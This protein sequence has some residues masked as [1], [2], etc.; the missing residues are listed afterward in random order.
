MGIWNLK[1]VISVLEDREIADDREAQNLAGWIWEE[2]MGWSPSESRDLNSE[3]EEKLA[4]SI[5]RLTVGEP[6]QYI[7]GYAWFYGIKLKV[8]PD[9][10]IPRPETEELVEW[11]LKDLK[12]FREKTIRIL[13]IGTG[14]GCIVIALKKH[15]GEKADIIAMD[16]SQ[17]ALNVAAENAIATNTTIKF[18]QRDFL[19]D[20][21]NDLGQFDIIVS[22]PPY[23][24]YQEAGNEI[25]DQLRYEPSVALY[26]A[27]DDPNVFYSGIAETCMKYLFPHGACYVEMNEFR[28]DQIQQY[29]KDNGWDKIEIRKDLQGSNRMLK[30]SPGIQN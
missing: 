7:S 29:F 18:I 19:K 27:G 1:K 8:T 2:I 21:L 15:L 25:T 22:N 4:V 5:A 28:V 6:V 20:S 10:L 24:L 13:D 23:I 16:I 12:N 14:S 9:V 3:E 11:I 30:A 26:P 17:S